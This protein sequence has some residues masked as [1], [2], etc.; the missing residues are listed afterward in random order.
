MKSNSARPGTRE[1]STIQLIDKAIAKV[2]TALVIIQA[3]GLNRDVVVPK[4]VTAYVARY[5]ANAAGLIV[6]VTGG[7][8]QG[9][10]DA[11]RMATHEVISILERRGILIGREDQLLEGEGI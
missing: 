1:R 3:G 6:I 2:M 8:P 9:V 10:I 5:G 11:S 4:A 7:A